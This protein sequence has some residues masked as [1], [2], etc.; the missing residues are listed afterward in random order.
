[1]N[2]HTRL[3]RLISPNLPLDVCGVIAR[4]LSLFDSFIYA[5]ICKELSRIGRYM[6]NTY[7]MFSVLDTPLFNFCMDNRFKPPMIRV[8]ND[9]KDC[10][11]FPTKHDN[12]YENYKSSWGTMS[13]EKYEHS[14]FLKT[15][16]PDILPEIH[17]EIARYLGEEERLLYSYL[18][19]K[20]SNNKYHKKHITQ[21]EFMLYA[22]GNDALLEFGMRYRFS[23]RALTVNMTN[24][25]KMQEY[26]SI[27]SRYR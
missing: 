23:S 25:A 9:T 15:I 12:R 5:Y 22:L 18:C 17:S 3:L 2:D 16:L 11:L 8:R 20:I 24:N 10:N 1:M 14:R 13:D 21:K 26:I 7:Y 27:W 6:S 19:K 4:L